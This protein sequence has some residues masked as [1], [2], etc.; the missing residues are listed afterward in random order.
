MTEGKSGMHNFYFTPHSVFFSLRKLVCADTLSSWPHEV[1]TARMDDKGISNHKL[2]SMTCPIATTR[3]HFKQS[4]V[5]ACADDDVLLGTLESNLAQLNATND[6][7]QMWSQFK[8]V[9]YFFEINFIP[10]RKKSTN[11]H[12]PWVPRH[13][14]E[15]KWKIKRR[16]KAGMTQ[17]LNGLTKSMH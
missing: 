8:S 17:D 7:H 1:C 14:I 16:R 4:F 5:Y 10:S 13:I 6:V 2:L 11:R 15:L 12:Y 9:I 3:A